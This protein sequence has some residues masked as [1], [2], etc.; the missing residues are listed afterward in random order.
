LPQL[1]ALLVASKNDNF[2]N[3]DSQG[4]GG[5]GY[6]LEARSPIELATSCLPI[7]DD[8]VAAVWYIKNRVTP[9]K[10]TEAGRAS[11]RGPPRNWRCWPWYGKSLAPARV[12]TEQQVRK[13]ARGKCVVVLM[14]HRLV[15][16]D[17][18][19][20]PA[21]PAWR[22]RV[23]DW[24]VVA[25]PDAPVR[26]NSLAYRVRIVKRPHN[27]RLVACPNVINRTDPLPMYSNQ[28]Y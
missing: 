2:D 26:P 6:R 18:D 1:A 22:A 16:M 14:L 11:R 20:R 19:H 27:C 4:E 8:D 24:P 17:R 10:R 28:N 25:E 3:K 15:E 12:T 13:K 23:S 21:A 7:D 5:G 9:T